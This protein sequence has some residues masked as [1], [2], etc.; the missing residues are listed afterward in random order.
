MENLYKVRLAKIA[1]DAVSH[2]NEKGDINMCNS[3]AEK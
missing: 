1:L 3:I 2:M